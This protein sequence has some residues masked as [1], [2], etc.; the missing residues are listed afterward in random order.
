M[1][2]S[3]VFRNERL[4]VFILLP[5]CVLCV[6]ARLFA[7]MC[8][9]CAW[10]RCTAHYVCSMGVCV[11]VVM[12]HGLGAWGSSW[13]GGRKWEL[14][15]GSLLWWCLCLTSA[16][17]LH[18]DAAWCPVG[19]NPGTK[20]FDCEPRRC[21]APYPITLRGSRTWARSI[22]NWPSRW[23]DPLSPPDPAGLSF[24]GDQG[25]ASCWKPGTL[26]PGHFDLSCCVPW[27]SWLSPG[28]WPPRGHR[29]WSRFCFAH[30]NV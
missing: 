13:A 15:V 10:C 6:C 18:L 16:C 29:T 3:L 12:D 1:W 27:G 5:V 17:I 8:C 24:L 23:T 2:A 22:S 21:Q 25:S 11:F 9:L 30:W 4:R 14:P 28:P 26:Q 20:S 19:V 7:D